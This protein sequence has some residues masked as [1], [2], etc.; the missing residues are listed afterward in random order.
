M[1]APAEQKDGYNTY[2]TAGTVYDFHL[3]NSNKSEVLATTGNF[4]INFTVLYSAAFAA[5]GSSGPVHCAD[6]LGGE[7][8]PIIGRGFPRSALSGCPLV[9]N[10]HQ[11]WGRAWNKNQ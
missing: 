11:S 10:F 5:T 3:K 2:I 1:F 7:L 9:Q 8:P 6:T 4:C